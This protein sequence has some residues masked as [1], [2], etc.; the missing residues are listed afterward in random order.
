MGRAPVASSE[1]QLR[2][3]LDDLERCEAGLRACGREETAHL[4]SVAM[5]ELR[6]RL[7]GISDAELKALCDEMLPG[8]DVSAER[9]G[10]AESSPRP[11][12]RPLLRLVK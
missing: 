12:R 4:V 9:A 8:S 7:N 11:R 6:M 1:Q 2:S 3:I 10:E 5:L